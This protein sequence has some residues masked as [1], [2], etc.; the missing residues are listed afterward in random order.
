MFSD[1]SVRSECGHKAQLQ[2]L[3]RKRNKA[4]SRA[5]AAVDVVCVCREREKEARERESHKESQA[6]EEKESERAVRSGVEEAHWQR[7]SSVEPEWISIYENKTSRK[8]EREKREK[9]KL[10]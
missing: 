9:C 2:K 4:E 10:R 5:A 7:E 3:R 8:R 1:F 6:S